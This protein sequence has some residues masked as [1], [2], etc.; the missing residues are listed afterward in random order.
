MQSAWRYVLRHRHQYFVLVRY[1]LFKISI[2]C[3]LSST[4]SADGAPFML[5]LAL[6]Q[7]LYSAL[8]WSYHDFSTSPRSVRSTDAGT[9]PLGFELRHVHAVSPE[10]RVVW[11][12][13]KQADSLI[14]ES[15]SP[16]YFVQTRAMKSTKP[17]SHDDFLRARSLTRVQRQ[18]ANLDW[19]EDDIIGP[20]VESR[21]AILDLAKMTNNAYVQPDEPGWYDLGSQ[22]NVVSVGTFAFLYRTR[23]AYGMHP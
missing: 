14:L 21:E 18:S 20:D 7:F 23:H 10:A 2:T 11:A 16:P 13:V 17:S 3:L 19:D 9:L 15:A 5:P 12:D 22:W 4:T 8:E 1:S 6:L